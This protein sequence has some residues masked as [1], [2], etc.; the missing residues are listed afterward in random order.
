[1]NQKS[2]HWQAMKTE[3][4]NK[5]IEFNEQ[6]IDYWS[7]RTSFCAQ[8]WLVRIYEYVVGITMGKWRIKRDSERSGPDRMQGAVLSSA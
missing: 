1:M 8:D 7:V 2:I 5:S 3:F 6:L 4:Q